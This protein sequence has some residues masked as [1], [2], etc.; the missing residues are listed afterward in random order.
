MTKTVMLNQFDKLLLSFILAYDFFEL[1][2]PGFSRL[3][4]D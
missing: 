3:S 4:M 2:E 1:Q